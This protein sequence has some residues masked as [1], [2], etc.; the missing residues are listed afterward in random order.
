MNK[1]I[2]IFKIKVQIKKYKQSDIII[3]LFNHVQ[4][5]I[6]WPII[7]DLSLYY[8]YTLQPGSEQI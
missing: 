4:K 8:P 3:F 1:L 2:E 5:N 6:H 7:M